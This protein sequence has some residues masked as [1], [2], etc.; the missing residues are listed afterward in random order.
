MDGTPIGGGAEGI[1]AWYNRTTRKATRSLVLATIVSGVGMLAFWALVPL[2]VTMKLQ[3]A[4]GAF[5]IPVFGGLW[6]AS[7]M[8]IWLIPMRELSFRGQ[9]SFERTE[10]RLK[11]AIDERLLPAIDMWTRIGKRVEESVLPRIEST[12][13][14][15]KS[16]IA[17]AKKTVKGI[18]NRVGPIYESTKRLEMAVDGRL[19]LMATEV[20][21][22]SKAVQAFFAPHGTPPDVDAAISF[23]GSGRN[24]GVKHKN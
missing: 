23:L 15:A 22:A 1:R 16:A 19:G 4:N 2:A 10:E 6:I 24:G 3:A 12:L 13:D 5:T 14:E 8:F 7:F 11:S 17:D 21:A 18:E 9:E 20:T